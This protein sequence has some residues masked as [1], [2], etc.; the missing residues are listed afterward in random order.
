MRI[1]PKIKGV[2]IMA[3]F[4]ITV[5]V[6]IVL[7]YIFRKNNRIVRR[8]WAK[9][10]RKIISYN[11]TQ[12][13]ILDGEAQLVLINHQGALDI[14]TLE[15]L[16]PKDLCWVTKQEIQDIPLFG[17]VVTAPHM[18]A[19]KRQDKRSLIKMLKEAKDRVQKGRVIAIFP[20]GTRSDG[21]RL[22]KFKQGA[23]FLA[24]K[25]NLKVLPV[26]ITGSR[27]IFDTQNLLSSGKDITVNFLPTITPEVGT[28]W[29]EQMQEDMKKV[30][31][32]E[33]A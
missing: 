7:M 32:N 22:L 8:N 4:I 31:E 33:L 30:L 16:H 15:E 5:L 13:G 20:E 29:Y 2:L 10:Q 1:L 3:Q 11:I 17:H 27:E 19:V 28:S 25:L 21:K 24:E 18:I 26:V 12:K 6:V 9:L 23:K 14:V